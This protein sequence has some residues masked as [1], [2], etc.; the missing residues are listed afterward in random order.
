M[1]IVE[2]LTKSYGT[3]ELF[4]N[5]NFT[6]GSRERVGL[7]GRNGHGKTVRDLPPRD[8]ALMKQFVAE[9]L[10]TEETFLESY[11]SR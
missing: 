9:G 6:I 2:N 11:F 4:E 3:Q 10:Y 1:I 5:I 7:V 8:L